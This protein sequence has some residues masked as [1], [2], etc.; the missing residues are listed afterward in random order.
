MTHHK[1]VPQCLYDFKLP[2][3]PL[4]LFKLNALF[5]IGCTLGTPLKVDAATFNKARPASTRILVERDVT[6]LDVKRIWIGDTQSGF[7]QEVIMEQRPHYCQHCKMF[8]HNSER[9]YMLKPPNRRVY[10]QPQQE[11]DDA[12]INL[13]EVGNKKVQKKTTTAAGTDESLVQKY[14]SCVAGTVRNGS[15][16]VG[17]ISTKDNKLE[18]QSEVETMG[19]E[20]LASPSPINV[21]NQ[22]VDLVVES[23]SQKLVEAMNK[24]L[25]SDWQI[26]K[27]K[28]KKN[29]KSEGQ[30][31]GKGKELRRL[32]VHINQIKMGS[33]KIRGRTRSRSHPYSS[34]PLH[35]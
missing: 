5:N 26:Q 32:E 4:H 8:G 27:T 7:W 19:E 34:P 14:S 25:E 24:E 33:N 3:L 9:C 16:V 21:M 13:Q 10:Q 2:K 31:L 28:K 22:A 23:P 11:L 6:L 35:D 17:Q 29:Y 30:D 15:N 18:I 12:N 20:I 1:N